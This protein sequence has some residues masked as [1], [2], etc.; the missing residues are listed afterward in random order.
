LVVN[1]HIHSISQGPGH[2]RRVHKVD[3]ILPPSSTLADL[4]NILHLSPDPRTTIATVNSRTVPTS[5]VLEQAAEVHLISAV[6]ASTRG[7][8][9]E[10]PG[11]IG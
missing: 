1:V 5:H 4:L 3:V 10:N 11:K 7:T 6:P 8:R 9:L 2:E